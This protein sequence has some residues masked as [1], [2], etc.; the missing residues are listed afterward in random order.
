MGSVEGLHRSGSAVFRGIADDAMDQLCACGRAVSF[1]AGHVLFERGQD[2]DNLMILQD[3]VV[4]LL[5]PVQIMGVTRDVT[6]ETKQVGD[7]VAWSALV[8]PYHF[9][10]SARC[11]GDCTLASFTRD[12]LES[13]FDSDPQSG[14]LFMRNLAG[15]I[16]HRLQR[17]Q[18]MWVHDLQAS[19]AKRL[20]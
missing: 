8:S 18:T 2:A 3:G 16:G 11:A 13:F 17:M 1:K 20:E 6:M 19:A 5:F 10:L 9:T 14:Y 7:L 15:E 4:E 12:A